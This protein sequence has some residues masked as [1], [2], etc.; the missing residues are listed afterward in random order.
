[1]SKIIKDVFHSYE[2]AGSLDGVTAIKVSVDLQPSIKM[3]ETFGYN[4]T[5]P[6]FCDSNCGEDTI[7]E[8]ENEQNLFT[9]HYLI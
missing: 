1:M 7:I 6:R 2:Q 9:V 8:T 3:E 5:K 4:K